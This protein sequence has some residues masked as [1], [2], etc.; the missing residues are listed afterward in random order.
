MF[1]YFTSEKVVSL[2][3]SACTVLFVEINLLITVKTK[4]I[5]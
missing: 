4:F 2:S 5:S 1:V 3:Y